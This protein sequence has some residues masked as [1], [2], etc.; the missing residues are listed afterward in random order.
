MGFVYLLLWRLSVMLVG[1]DKVPTIERSLEKETNYLVSSTSKIFA[2]FIF[3]SVWLV[4]L[5]IDLTG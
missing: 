5:T 4:Q 2:Q 3:Y 1:E